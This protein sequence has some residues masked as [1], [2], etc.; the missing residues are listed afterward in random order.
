MYETGILLSRAVVMDVE[1]CA[2]SQITILKPI[3]FGATDPFTSKNSLLP[4]NKKGKIG[5]KSEKKNE[6]LKV[7]S[8]LVNT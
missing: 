4:K 8:N 1:A 6:W 2:T 5:R 7:S 3:F